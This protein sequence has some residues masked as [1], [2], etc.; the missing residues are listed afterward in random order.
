MVLKFTR[1]AA[2]WLVAGLLAVPAWAANEGQADLDKAT[3][4]KLEAE[5]LSDLEKVA[6]LCESAIKKGLD[7]EN[8]GFANQLLS[9]VLLEVAR[10]R[11]TAIFEQ[12]PP[13]P[14]W[15]AIRRQALKDLEK[16]LKADPKLPE[17]HMLIIKLQVLPGG[18]VKA[19]RKS[20]DAAV[21]LLADDKPQLAKALV[22]RGAL[23]EDADEQLADFNKA[24]EADPRSLEALRVRAAV[25]LQKD[26]NEKA[27]ADLLK[28]LEIEPNNPQVQ[29]AV[30]EILAKSEKFDEALKHVDKLIALNPKSPIGFTQRALI[31]IMQEKVDDALV[32]L[33]EALKLDPQ[34]V[35]ALLLRGQVLAQQ[36]KFAEARADVERALRIQPELSQAILL[37]SMIAAQSKKWGDAISDIKTLLQTDPQNPELRLQL[38]AYYAADSRP[39]KAI[40]VFEQ[41]IDADADNWKARRARADALLSI[42]EHAKA[43]EDYT[44]ALQKEPNDS[45]MLNNLAWV[46]ATSPDDDVRDA[47]RSIEIGLKASEA[48]KYEA[49]HILSTLAAGYAESGDWET[50]IKWSSKA[51][52]LS[53]KDTK[54]MEEDITA[55][56][57]KEL[58]SYKE[59]KPWREKQNTEENKK[60]LKEKDSDLE[61]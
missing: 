2:M 46:L 54:K 56:L 22:M 10:K 31:R 26:D 29:A 48:T 5:T 36:D 7:A 59:K 17:A 40:E 18:D 44:E 16:A 42:G 38:G 58:E 12:N 23:T 49:P 37:R 24:V 39:R 47:K 15:Q 14:R 8:T 20:A 27:V 45:H 25:Y 35:G 19:A 33:N 50:A 9:S 55:Q 34:N 61:A 28:I 21:K 52:E 13:D 30:A 6:G 43:V 53:E 41:L 60:P 11:T 57:K 3:E 4:A 51:V 1:I 32:D